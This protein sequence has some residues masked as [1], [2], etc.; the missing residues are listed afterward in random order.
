MLIS[1]EHLVR[2]CLICLSAVQIPH[3]FVIPFCTISTPGVYSSGVLFMLRNQPTKEE[4][5]NGG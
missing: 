5:D 4:R 3:I 1:F 2:L